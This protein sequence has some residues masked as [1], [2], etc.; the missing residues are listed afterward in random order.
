MFHQ[1]RPTDTTDKTQKL[2]K[3][4]IPA[5]H[6]LGIPTFDNS[7]EPYQDSPLPGMELDNDDGLMT[8][9]NDDENNN[10]V[11]LEDINQMIQDD[12]M[13]N[14][15]QNQNNNI[16]NNNQNIPLLNNPY[17]NILSDDDKDEIGNV[18]IDLSRGINNQLNNN[19]TQ[20]ENKENSNQITQTT[21]P[22]T[23]TEINQM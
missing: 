15:N 3:S 18:I 11:L 16:E 1:D 5:S 19:K 4:I 22:T 17:I 6:L 9:F 2:E 8:T 10:Q 21:I 23:N 14:Q 13:Q 12:M 20:N 7:P